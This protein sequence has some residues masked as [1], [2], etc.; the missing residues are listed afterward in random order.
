MTK[1]VP[2]TSHDDLEH[3]DI[4][5]W[6]L[7]DQFSFGDGGDDA[8]QFDMS[9]TNNDNNFQEMRDN[10]DETATNS[11]LILESRKISNPPTITSIYEPKFLEIFNSYTKFAAAY[12]PNI[13]LT[14]P[15]S[16]H[17]M[18]LCLNNLLPFSNWARTTN[19]SS[20]IRATLF[21][22][23]DMRPEVRNGLAL[24]LVYTFSAA[25]AADE[26]EMAAATTKPVLTSTGRGL[27]HNYIVFCIS[28]VILFQILTFSMRLQSPQRIRST[29]SRC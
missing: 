2:S 22:N 20:Y 18:T 9:V 21:E 16:Q 12:E 17:L 13:D 28:S 19:T 26:A 27:S 24:I 3:I 8:S 23:P 6:S 10:F 5:N 29:C 14:N 4:S 1:M 11:G 25:K 15:A 7:S